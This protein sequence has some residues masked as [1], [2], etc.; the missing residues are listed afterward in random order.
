MRTTVVETVSA[1]TKTAVAPGR[2]RARLSVLPI[3]QSDQSDGRSRPFSRGAR[4]GIMLIR[5]FL[6]VSRLKRKRLLAMT[7]RR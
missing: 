4:W 1:A 6:T 7:T 5:T 3:A 2:W